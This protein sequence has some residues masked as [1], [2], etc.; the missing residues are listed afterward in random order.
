M[1]VRVQPHPDIHDVHEWSKLLLANLLCVVLPHKKQTSLTF[2]NGGEDLLWTSLHFSI[3]KI[4]KM[5]AEL[6]SCFNFFPWNSCAPYNFSVSGKTGWLLSTLSKTK[7][8]F[9]RRRGACLEEGSWGSHFTKERLCL[10]CLTLYPFQ[11]S[12]RT[13]WP[14]DQCLLASSFPFW[15]SLRIFFS[16]GGCGWHSRDSHLASL[17]STATASN[18]SLPLFRTIL[19]GKEEHFMPKKG[20]G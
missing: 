11:H 3:C 15:Y 9:P 5:W 6:W 4:G 2:T 7:F 1:S 12:L 10:M 18:H 13:A 16:W 20:K 19:P 8:I 14:S 17:T